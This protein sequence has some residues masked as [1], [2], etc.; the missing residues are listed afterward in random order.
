MRPKGLA[1]TGGRQKGS[2]NKVTR[3]LKEALDERG[4]CIPEKIIELY[5]TTDN[6]FIRFKLLELASEYSYKKPKDGQEEEDPIDAENLMDR[7]AHVSNEAL[8]L[9][10]NKEEKSE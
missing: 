1:K 5:E 9:I 3:G 2:L 6:E 8:V 10:A 4:F 7:F